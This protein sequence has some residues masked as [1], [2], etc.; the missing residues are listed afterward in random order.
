MSNSNRPYYEGGPIQSYCKKRLNYYRAIILK[1]RERDGTREYL[2]HYA[3]SNKKFDKWIPWIDL[4]PDPIKQHYKITGK[5]PAC[6]LCSLY[7]PNLNDHLRF[8]HECDICEE[9]F[10]DLMGHI[11]HEHEVKYT[12]F[13]SFWMEMV[14]NVLTSPRMCPVCRI[15]Y[16]NVKKHFRTSHGLIIENGRFYFREFRVPIDFMKRHEVFFNINCKKIS[17]NRNK[18]IS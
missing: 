17:Q 11:Y 15:Y 14:D 8:G 6:P 4:R 12:E 16:T 10:I 2:V 13:V 18:S 7:Y 1:I 3:N 5:K 9:Y